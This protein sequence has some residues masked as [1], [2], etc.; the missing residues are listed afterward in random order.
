MRGTDPLLSFS[1][2]LLGCHPQFQEFSPSDVIGCFYEVQSFHVNSVLCMG[3]QFPLCTSVLFSCRGFIFVSSTVVT[4][5]PVLSFQ[6][7]PAP[8]FFVLPYA[9]FIIYFL[10]RIALDILRSVL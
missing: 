6:D 8:F 1:R 10:L 4:T 5:P 9:N 2:R 7:F 3:F